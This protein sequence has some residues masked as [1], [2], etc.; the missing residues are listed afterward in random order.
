MARPLT[1]EEDDCSLVRPNGVEDQIDAV[2][3][4]APAVLRERLVIV[5]RG[6]PD[7]L[8]SETLVHL[9]RHGRRAEDQ[10]LVSLV[11]PVLLGRCEANLL[12]KVPDG[13]MPDA[14]S[15]RE[16]I[17]C[18]FSELFATDGSG[19][20][21]NEL[22]FYECRFNRAFKFFRIDMVRR[23]IARLRPITQMPA[24]DDD[25]E[26]G[27]HDEVF[28]RVSEAFCTAPTQEGELALSELHDAILSLP[29]DERDAVILVHILGYQEESEDPKTMTAATRCDCSGRTIRNRLTRA[30]VKLARF[31]EVL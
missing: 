7:Y 2:L 20:N 15:L 10:N 18:S 12:L 3:G 16:E 1:T 26:P 19:D 27:P 14:A 4:L 5:D 6:N 13:Q 8:F 22:N 25:G 11:L 17:L 29:A 9:V 28:A 21:P 23:E 31:K 24:P 30:A